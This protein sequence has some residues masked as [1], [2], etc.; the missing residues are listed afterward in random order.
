MQS[1]FFKRNI[2]L[3]IR[4]LFCQSSSVLVFFPAVS[5]S[6]YISEDFQFGRGLVFFT[7]KKRSYEIKKTKFAK[8]DL[9]TV[10]K[11]FC[12]KKQST[13]GRFLSTPS[14]PNAKMQTEKKVMLMIPGK[15]VFTSLADT[16]AELKLL[17]RSETKSVVSYPIFLT[18]SLV[19]L[20]YSEQA[21]QLHK[22]QISHVQI[23]LLRGTKQS[24]S[25]ELTVDG[26]SAMKMKGA[27]AATDY[28]TTKQPKTHSQP[29]NN[30]PKG[31]HYVEKYPYMHY[32]FGILAGFLNTC[33]VYQPLYMMKELQW[34]IRL[35][36]A[37]ERDRVLG[38][39]NAGLAPPS[40]RPEESSRVE[41][42]DE[43]ECTVQLAQTSTFIE[44]LAVRHPFRVLR[45]S[46]ASIQRIEQIQAAQ[47]QE[48][49]KIQ[50]QEQKHV[51]GLKGLNVKM[52]VNQAADTAEFELMLDQL[53]RIA[54][55]VPDI[56][57]AAGWNAGEAA[58]QRLAAQQ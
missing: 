26:D 56:C 29:V 48:S 15:P 57:G 19:Q 36:A 33:L 4:L 34:N 10:V 14:R 18:T 30:S 40:S 32:V 8:Y 23:H 17:I 49:A 58:G 21:V 43:L 52:A 38:H 37:E 5:V 35:G 41:D 44:N 16:K 20:E 24:I 3:L 45:G 46:T 9:F 25:T 1:Y 55:A 39:S 2:L 7:G 13:F 28:C 54:A 47:S 6:Q 12:E 27:D 51:K 42:N 31:Q 22:F 11:F 50:E 53:Q